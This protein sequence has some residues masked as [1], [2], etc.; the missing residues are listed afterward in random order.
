MPSNH[1][2]LCLPSVFPT[3]RVFS[4]ELVFASDGQSI[5]ASALASVLPVNIQGWFP[6]V[7]TGLIFAVQ[8]TLKSLL[9]HHSSK[10]S[11]LSCS[12]FFIVQFSHSYVTTSKTTALTIYGPL[13]AKWCLHRLGFSWLFFQGASVF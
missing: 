13:S 1:L 11:I 6:L 3:I 12:A 5:G 8:G 2:I 9:Q 4:N 10:T 7:L